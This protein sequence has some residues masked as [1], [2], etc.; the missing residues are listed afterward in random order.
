MRRQLGSSESP[1]V[2]RNLRQNEPSEA[3][4]AASEGGVACVRDCFGADQLLIRAVDEADETIITT[5]RT[6]E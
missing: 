2:I 1:S 5:I 3:L 6:T 4:R